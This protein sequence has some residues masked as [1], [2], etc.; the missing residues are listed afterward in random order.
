MRA[1][2]RSVGCVRAIVVVAPLAFFGCTALPKVELTAYTTAYSETRI[3]TNGILDIVVPYERIVIRRAA[4]GRQKTVQVRVP[5]DPATDAATVGPTGGAGT[6]NEPPP[7]A[8]ATSAPKV[9][10]SL[11]ESKAR[12]KSAPKVDESLL[13]PKSKAKTK[14]AP[15]VDE[16]LLEPKSP[17]KPAPP[18]TKTVTRVVTISPCNEGFGGVD[19]YCYETRDAYAD[20]GDPPLVASFRNL[21]N[22]VHRFNA[23]L[24]AYANG[25]SGPLIE[26]ELNGLSSAVTT[27]STFVPA[28]GAAGAGVF[29]TRF[30]GIVGKLV[31]IAQFI[32]P[33][34]DRAQLRSF[35]LENYELVDDAIELMATSSGTL[36]SNVAVGTLFFARTPNV[37]TQALTARQREIR[38]LIANWTVL[39]DDS[40]QLLRELKGAIEVPDGLETRLRNLNESTVTTRI[41]TAAIRKQ[42]ATLGT[43]VIRP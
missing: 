26:Q 8:P 5:V 33:A 30:N 39:L 18:R 40:R 21:S 15:K 43:P 17:P 27:I 4:Q 12:P 11:L 24:I 20:I 38:G 13:E 36:Y 3:I 16:T 22:V 7:G 35:L 25:V 23:L 14:S 37:S 42:I 31:P 19:P 34:I 41:D 1:L 32:G 6:A 29:A 10:E 28:S 9:D 2:V